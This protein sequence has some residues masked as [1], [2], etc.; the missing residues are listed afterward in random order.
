[1]SNSPF[2][3]DNT[4]TTLTGVIDKRMKS[5]IIPNGVTCIGY[6]AFKE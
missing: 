3:F 2:L 5:V 1:M 6:K 4:K